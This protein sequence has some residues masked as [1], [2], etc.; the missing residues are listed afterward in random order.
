MTIT[1]TTT[2]TTT[3]YVLLNFLFSSLVFGKSSQAICAW[4]SKAGAHY[5][6]QPLMLPQ[7]SNTAYQIIDGDIPCTPEVEPSFGYSWNFCDNVPSTQ[8]PGPCKSQGKTGVVLQY[9]QY[10][11][12]DIYCYILG[13]YDSTQYEITYS[14]LDPADPSKGISVRYPAGEKCSSTNKKTRTATIDIECA[15]VHS[16]VVSAQEPGVCDYHLLMKSYY[17]CPTECPVTANGLCNSHGHCAYDKKAQ[18]PYCYCNSGYGG[19]ACDQGASSNS[20]NTYD[21]YSVQ[22]GLLITLLILALVLTG[23]VVYLAYRVAE[24]RKT[25]INSHYTSL[26]GESEM[27]E[28]LTFSR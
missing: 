7:G 1:R 15:N 3:F 23:G 14:Q 6:L 13:H 28:T 5:N 17:G 18:K 25:Q 26:P 16:V 24:F 9:A 27:V 4:D 8:I 10:G 19:A 11:P 20:N 21:G 22:L 2:R 12:D